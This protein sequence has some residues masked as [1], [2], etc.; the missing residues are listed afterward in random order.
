[1]VNRGCHSHGE[2][3][4]D[5]TVSEEDVRKLQLS[6][7]RDMGLACEPFVLEFR[8]QRTARTFLLPC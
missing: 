6:V 5:P 1:M 4:W 7:A 8:T 2:V 3:E